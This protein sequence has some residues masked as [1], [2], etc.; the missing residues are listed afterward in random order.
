VHLSSENTA[1]VLDSTADLP[2]PAARHANWRLVPL[3]VRF[4]DETF[5]DHVDLTPREFYG[6]L[7]DAPATPKSSQP[8]PADF[9][10]VFDGLARFERI[11]CVLISG[12]L[13]GTSESAR[14]AAQ[15]HGDRVRVIDSES[16]SGGIVI[17]ADAI[18]RRLE[19]GTT[20]EELDELAA[21]FK[22]EAGLLFTVDTLD[23]LVRGGRVGKAAGLA[24]Q[25]LNVKPIL[26]IRGGEV[27]PLKRVRGRTKA[28]AEFERLLVEATEDEPALHI[29]VAHADA[30]GEAEELATRVRRARPHASFDFETELGP[31]IG[32]HGGPGTLGLFWFRD[33]G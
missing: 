15:E 11:V 26:T 12:K 30:A 27:E 28:L 20:D 16:A 14:L 8:T 6:R 2:D 31:V 5:R 19:R 29:G 25:L 33:D 9:A 10:A 21:R 24:G 18:Q 1:L 3:Y 4:G 22:R 13:S 17:L 7:R 23:Y 32:T